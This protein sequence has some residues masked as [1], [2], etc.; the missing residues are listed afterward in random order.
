MALNLSR[1]SKVFFTTNVD[2]TTGKV[3]AGGFYADNTYELQILDGFTFSQNTNSEAVTLSEAGSAPVRGQRNFNT[4]LAPADFS[5]STYIRPKYE[6]NVITAEE[7]VLWNALFSSQNFKTTNSPLTITSG[8]LTVS[9]NNSTGILTVG[10]TNIGVSGNFVANDIVYV[11]GISAVT[12]TPSLSSAATTNYFNTVARVASVTTNTGITLEYIQPYTTAAVSA[13]TLTTA[14]TIKLSKVVDNRVLIG[15]TDGTGT[16]SSLTY[17]HIAGATQ[18]NLTI[19]GSSLPTLTVGD[20][21]NVNLTGATISANTKSIIAPAIVDS[22]GSTSLVLKYLNPATTATTITGTTAVTLTKTSLVRYANA[23]EASAFTYSTTATSDRHQLQ[24]FGL[25]YIIDNVCYAIDNCVLTQATIDF[26]LDGIA[27]VAWTGQ[28]TTVRKIA[29]NVTATGGSFG[30][31]IDSIVG[32]YTAKVDSGFKYITNKL[33]TAKLTSVNDLSNSGGVVVT[34][35]DFINLAITGGSITINNNV[36]YLTPSILSIVNEPAQ[37]FTGSRSIT[38]TLTCYLKT[39]TSPTA[40]QIA[41]TGELLSDMLKVVGNTTEPMFSLLMTVGGVGS[42]TP[43]LELDMPATVL[44][45]PTIDA[46]QV[47][48]TTINFTAEGS[49]LS[50]SSTSFD[51]TKTNDL[52]I[53]YYSN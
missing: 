5:F 11:S 15:G 35:G 50:G 7:S 43:K 48:S 23:T 26:A 13:V 22:S 2:S 45:V 33:S 1:N 36:T 39:G 21:Y 3:N 17:A 52:T 42:N 28:G 53:R 40:G 32:K 19:A 14:N 27:T 44:A 6:S 47:V 51:L 20:I 34:K 16:L 29:D 37:Y 49:V 24:K 31:A 25:V 18:G 4:S 41:D 9:Y 38:G 12:T 30:N 8:T 46:Q 10:G